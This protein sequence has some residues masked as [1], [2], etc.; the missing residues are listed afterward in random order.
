M[1]SRRDQI[2]QLTNERK[3]MYKSDTNSKHAKIII[4]QPKTDE[5]FDIS[6]FNQTLVPSECSTLIPV[7]SRTYCCKKYSTRGSEN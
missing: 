1:S 5:P 2:R 6:S 7:P 4:H 3:I